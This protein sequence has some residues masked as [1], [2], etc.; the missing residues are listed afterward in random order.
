M[1]ESWALGA[2]HHRD[3]QSVALAGQVQLG[4]GLAAIDRVGA[5]QVPPLTAAGEGVHPDPLQIDPAGRAQLVQQQRLEVVEHAGAGPLVQPPPAG[6]GRAAAQLTGGQQAPW[7]GGA[8]HEDQHRHTVAVGNAAGHATAG[9]GWWRW[10]E[11]LDAPPQLL[12]QEAVH[13]TG[14]AR[15]IRQQPEALKPPD[16]PF[17]NVL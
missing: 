7:R 2:E 1:V 11:R 14:H 4:P 6:G 9:P 3:R 5:G 17:R 15:S 8:G 16:R 13:E 12:R 10:Q